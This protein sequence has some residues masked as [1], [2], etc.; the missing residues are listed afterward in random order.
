MFTPNYF[1]PSP[2]LL[3]LDEEVPAQ[4]AESDVVI[5][6]RRSPLALSRFYR[7]LS[8]SF[9]NQFVIYSNDFLVP[10]G[11]QL[12][13]GF[14]GN[15]DIALRA[16]RKII[17]ISGDDRILRPFYN[18]F[19]ELAFT[20]A[21]SIGNVRDYI[22]LKKPD[23]LVLDHFLW[24]QFHNN[25]QLRTMLQNEYVFKKAPGNIGVYERIGL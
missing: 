10:F 21:G 17:E 1:H 19:P 16:R 23:I 14:A 6:T 4:T 20:C 8:D 3:W 18:R 12:P 11:G 13:K 15:M 22:R 7:Y 5:Y 25:F 2:S 24:R 9:G